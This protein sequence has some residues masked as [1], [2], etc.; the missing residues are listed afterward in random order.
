[1]E[2]EPTA[3]GN[4]AQQ[5][6]TPRGRR[7]WV[8]L[9]E[10]FD[11]AKDTPPAEG[12]PDDT[13]VDPNA[14]IDNEIAKA[15]T[16]AWL[17][18][19]F[20][21]PAGHRTNAQAGYTIAAAVAAAIVGAGL[22]TSVNEA[23]VWVQLPLLISLALWLYAAW[24]FMRTVAFQPNLGGVVHGSD[25]KT[26]A[27]DALQRTWRERQKIARRSWQAQKVARLAGIATF[28]ALTLLVLQ[29]TLAQ[30]ADVTVSLTSSGAQD[31]ASLCGVKHP[32]ANP[33][34]A[35]VDTAR[36]EDAIVEFHDVSCGGRQQTLR[37]PKAEI[38][39]TTH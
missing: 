34:Q 20:A 30:E 10:G 14:V 19:F 7:W 31:L 28:I 24:K 13:P 5:D 11:P 15:A 29:P 16:S 25:E 32:L 26:L 35:R 1:M 4:A 9:R 37:L 22:L 21:S 8:I 17:S 2:R 36:L 18:S 27:R 12:A 38:A 39:G 6:E 33:F 3:H 23:P